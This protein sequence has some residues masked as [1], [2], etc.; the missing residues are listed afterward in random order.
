M[1]V[2]EAILNRRSIRKYLDKEIETEKIELLKDALSWAPSA[3]NLQA[4]KFYF[5]SAK[6]KEKLITAFHQ[7]WAKKVPL[8][9]V[10]CGNKEKITDKF[11]E[12]NIAKYNHLDVAA[13]IENLMLQAVELD[14]GT[15]WI[16][17]VNTEKT[18]EILKVPEELNVLCAVAV[19]Y[20]AEKPEKKERQNIIEEMH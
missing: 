3:G 15:C 7:D 20:P 13:S 4:R 11:G 2:K 17:K 16:G 18:K 6:T 10:C 19:G 5:V 12:E 9:I 8:I 1:H 14:L